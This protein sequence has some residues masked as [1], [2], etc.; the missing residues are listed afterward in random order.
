MPLTEYAFCHILNVLCSHCDVPSFVACI[1]IPPKLIFFVLSSSYF[2]GGVC[3]FVAR[4]VDRIGK[5][6]CPYYTGQ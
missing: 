5:Y 2:V 1:F 4:G 3:L 6:I